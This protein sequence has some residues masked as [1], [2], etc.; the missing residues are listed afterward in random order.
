MKEIV[1]MTFAAIVFAAIGY[2][3]VKCNHLDDHI[4][5]A[6]RERNAAVKRAEV[7][8]Q[9]NDYLQANNLALTVK[10]NQCIRGK[11]YD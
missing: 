7:L 11:R 5:E 10:V 6:L 1:A 3:D 2:L 4:Q 9:Q 8:Q